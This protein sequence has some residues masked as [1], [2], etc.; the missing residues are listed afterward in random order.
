[1]ADIE[2]TFARTVEKYRMLSPGERVL[3]GVSGGADS[4]AL[5]HLL[6]GMG[7]ALNLHLEVAHLMHGLRGREAEEDAGFVR[8]LAERLGLPFHLKQINLLEEKSRLGKGNIEAIGREERYGFFAEVMRASGCGKL[9]TGHTRDDQVETLLMRLLRGAGRGALGAIR[10]VRLLDDS[11]P[12]PARWVIRP[13]IEVSKDQAAAYLRK[14]GIAFREDATNWDTSYLRN[15]VRH[16]L[17]P[18][19]R[20]RTDKGL[21]LRLA[22]TADLLWEEEKVLDEIA[23]ARLHA[24]RRGKDLDLGVLLAD[25]RALQRRVLRLWLRESGAGSGRLTFAHVEDCLKLVA[26]GPAHGRISLPGGW[27]LAKEY[28]A[29]RLEKRQF[30]RQ[31]PVCYTYPVTLGKELVIPEAGMR[32][33]TSVGRLSPD[34]WPKSPWQA[35]FDLRILDRGLTVRNFRAG[36]RFRPLGLGGQKKVKELFIERK[37]SRESRGRWPFLLS[38]DDILWIPGYARSDLA[39]VGPQTSEVVLAEARPEPKPAPSY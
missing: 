35:I 1:M 19:L 26:E 24:V 14:R 36:D 5:L 29:A 20:R 2:T 25:S 13:L 33:R 12:S 23:R 15:W 16:S 30:K 17:L 37:L 31:P 8:A 7:P 6:V 32:I 21:D 4:V 34:R 18:E 28:G 9:A 39:K 10:P 38:G 11:E 3:V 22:R 27:E